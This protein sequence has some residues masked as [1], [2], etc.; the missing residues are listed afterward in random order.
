GVNPP[1]LDALTADTTLVTLGVGGNDIGFGD[2]SLTCGLLSFTN[3]FGAPC[4]RRY[5]DRYTRRITA[6]EPKV[7]AVLDEIHRRSPQAKV[8]VVG[9][10]RLMPAGRGCWPM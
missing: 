5:G 6:V 8:V 2:I 9:Y 3:P 4:E 1:Q 10:L 7:A